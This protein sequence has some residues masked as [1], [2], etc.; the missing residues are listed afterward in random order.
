MNIIF[1]TNSDF[2]FHSLDILV[3]SNHKILSVVTNPPE[4]IGRQKKNTSNIIT[5]KCEELGIN[6]WRKN[7]SITLENLNDPTIQKFQ[8]T[9]NPYE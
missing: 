9:R 4:E 8:I 5:L 3:K 1:M 2:S 6:T 7:N